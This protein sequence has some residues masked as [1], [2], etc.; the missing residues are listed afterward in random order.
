MRPNAPICVPAFAITLGAVGVTDAFSDSG[1]SSPIGRHE[2]RKRDPPDSVVPN[3]ARRVPEAV[4]DAPGYNET[5]IFFPDE[6]LDMVMTT[7]SSKGTDLTILGLTPRPYPASLNTGLSMPAYSYGVVGVRSGRP[8]NFGPALID[9]QSSKMQP[10]YQGINLATDPEWILRFP[11]SRHPG[12]KKALWIAMKAGTSE[13]RV[14]IVEL[15]DYRPGRAVPAKITPDA[16]SY[17][18]TDLSII[19]SSVRKSNEIDVK[20]HD[21]TSGH[22]EYRGSAAAI[23]KVYVWENRAGPYIKSGRLLSCLTDWITP[24]DWLYLYY[25]TR[26]YISA[27]LRAV[28]DALK[29][30][31][32]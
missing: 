25:P 10:G 29:A 1:A 19:P 2:V 27:G 26:R 4:T 18:S 7:R 21:R 12:R 32:S 15:P 3:L 28:M 9:I 23:E 6:R 11:M 14:R 17:A 24:E 5:T 31:G 8:G 22:I 30:T 20:V 16:I 13:R